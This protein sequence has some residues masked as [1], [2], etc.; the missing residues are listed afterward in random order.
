MVVVCT[1]SVLSLCER[2]TVDYSVSV[3][4]WHR[5][6]SA[7]TEWT[8]PVAQRIRY[9]QVFSSNDTAR[10]HFLSGSLLTTHTHTYHCVG[11]YMSMWTVV[12]DM[13]VDWIV[14]SSSTF[15][16]IFNKDLPRTGSGTVMRPNSLLISA[17]YKLLV[18]YLA[19]YF[20]PYLFSCFL[21]RFS[22]VIYFFTCLLSDLS[23]SSRIGPFRLQ[24]R[25]S[26]QGLSR[27]KYE[28][29]KASTLTL[30]VSSNSI[31]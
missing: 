10:K 11:Q 24:A 4:V 8:V 27:S 17:L 13:P 22:L 7:S 30:G 1:L 2:L 12:T 26:Q 23:A 29:A 14:D 16:V 20:L 21:L 3:T 6:T 28:L 5:F 31:F 25:G 15:V 19:S 18:A 9:S